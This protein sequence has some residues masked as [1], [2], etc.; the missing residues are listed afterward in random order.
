MSRDWPQFMETTNVLL[1]YVGA[2]SSSQHWMHG[3]RE[4]ERGEHLEYS[5]LNI[6]IGPHLAHSEIYFPFTWRGGGGFLS[7]RQFILTLVT[8]ATFLMP[9][10]LQTWAWL[11]HHQKRLTGMWNT[12]QIVTILD[13]TFHFIDRSDISTTQWWKT[14]SFL[15]LESR[16][17]SIIAFSPVL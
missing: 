11:A 6:I 7:F 12:V 17:D 1:I 10:T 2:P 16:G 5:T 13:Y 3:I 4:M 9:G 14:W 15:L 8:C